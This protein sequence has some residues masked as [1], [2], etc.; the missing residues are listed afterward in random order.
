MITHANHVQNGVWQTALYSDMA[1]WG[2]P[3]VGVYQG[4]GDVMVVSPSM[5]SGGIKADGSVG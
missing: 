4:T 1:D 2:I 5:A 3:S